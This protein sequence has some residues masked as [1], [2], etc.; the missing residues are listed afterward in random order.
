[1]KRDWSAAGLDNS[2][3]VYVPRMHKRLCSR[4]FAVYSMVPGTVGKEPAREIWNA[5]FIVR[6][7]MYKYY[8]CVRRVKALKF[9]DLDLVYSDD[10]LEDAVPPRKVPPRKVRKTMFEAKNPWQLGCEWMLDCL[11]VPSLPQNI[12]DGDDAFDSKM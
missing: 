7:A 8:R 12:A 2:N 6:R 3:V 4:D 9:V 11:N 5:H 10:S 1:M